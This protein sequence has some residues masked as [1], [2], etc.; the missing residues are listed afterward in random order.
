[1]AV[2]TKAELIALFETGD[3]PSEQDFIDLI[4]SFLHATGEDWPVPLPAADLSQGTGTPLP[5]PLPAL[6]GRNL[7]NISPQE[8]IAVTGTVSKVDSNNLNITGDLEATFPP[9]RR[10][11]VSLPVSGTFVTGVVSAVYND[12]LGVTQIAVSPA[13]PSLIG[14][15]AWAGFLMPPEYGGSLSPDLVG[16]APA[17]HS[18]SEFVP[19]GHSHL[20]D[21]VQGL[22]AALSQRALL[23]SPAFE[24]TP[25]APQ[26]GAT[27][28]S[29][30]LA[31]TAW[32]QAL[33][34][35]SA[36]VLAETTS[37]GSS[38]ELFGVVRAGVAYICGSGST[39]ATGQGQNVSSVDRLTSV[40]LPDG[41]AAVAKLYIGTQRG[42]ALTIDGKLY[43]W[44]DNTRGALGVG[45]T[46]HRQVA[47]EVVFPV[48]VAGIVSLS[49]T[50]AG[51]NA[52]TSAYAI[53]SAGQL[54]VW[55]ANNNGQLGLG[56]LVD[57]AS[58]V[59]IAGAW[60]AVSPSSDGAYTSVLAVASDKALWGWGR[61]GSGELGLGNTTQQLLP[62]SLGRSG[63]VKAVSHGGNAGGPSN[64]SYVLDESGDAWLAGTNVHGQLGNGTT[65]ASTS[66]QK[67][68]ALDTDVIA[69]IFTG[70]AYYATAGAI[71]VDGSV[72]L[73]GYNGY[74]QLGTGDTANRSSPFNPG[75]S[76][77]TKGV[78][79]SNQSQS[80]TLLLNDLG[81][82][83]TAG[84][85][86]N[87]EL[88]DGSV[89]NRSIFAAAVGVV[90]GTTKAV[91]LAGYGRNGTCNIGVL[92]D[93]GGIV[94]WGNNSNGQLARG[95]TSDAGPARA[96]LF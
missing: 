78:I 91:D 55:G 46:V 16:A 73:W 1:M 70:G 3:R 22:V 4:D 53:D 67:L 11:R 57:R 21:D 7:L 37:P 54:F 86:N 6:D 38:S 80:T 27:D 95:S 92:L 56:D 42:Y 52:T 35:T 9:G 89:S 24:G 10:L 85:N 48:G 81:Q 87:G 43:A 17:D 61:N 72:R 77:V 83:L 29:A 68:D 13:L 5:D 74:G 8:W 26:P 25:T 33:L 40:S 60:S 41:A 62:V 65:V 45:D 44:G 51:G 39:Y 14:A 90:N 84:S 28:S 88:G 75:L 64:F 58:P 71:L 69:D 47:T 66:W 2:R 79:V 49:T 32:V 23:D 18:H 82:V 93:D 76:G 19:G 63:I 96:A 12:G 31:T 34:A 59:Q 30:R 15:S 36:P 20:L 50:G 94:T